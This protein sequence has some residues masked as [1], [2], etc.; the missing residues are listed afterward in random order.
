MVRQRPEQPDAQ[1]AATLT[2]S[3]RRSIGAV[4]L[5]T[6]VSA[7]ALFACSRAGAWLVVED[8]LEHAPAAAVF[9]GKTPFRAMEAAKLY[10]DGWTR[11]VWLT[12]GGLSAD[13]VALTQLGVDRPQEYVYNRQ[14]L[15]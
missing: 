2:T 5:L 4:A 7:L 13:E 8:P 14:V 6:A 10:K 12:E 1:C 3:R 15:E 9:G 11:E